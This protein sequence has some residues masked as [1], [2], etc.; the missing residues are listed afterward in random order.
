[1]IDHLVSKIRTDKRLANIVR[2]V[3]EIRWQF[4]SLVTRTIMLEV[5]AAS[6]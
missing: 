6:T 5:L 4:E 1:M 2:C 3:V